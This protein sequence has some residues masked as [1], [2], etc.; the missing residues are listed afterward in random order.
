MPFED[1]LDLEWMMSYD[2][3]K[4]IIEH[5][6]IANIHIPASY[7]KSVFGF[8]LADFF[9]KDPFYT[10]NKLPEE[11][12]KML[13]RL[14]VC[15]SNEYITH[16]RNDD[17]FLLMQKLH[18]VV[19]HQTETEWHIFMPDCIRT[20]LSKASEFDIGYHPGMREYANVLDDITACNKR[21]QEIVNMGMND[22]L[23]IPDMKNELTSLQQ[24]YEAGRKKHL[25]L[26]AKYPWAK[27]HEQMIQGSISSFL[28]FIAHLKEMIDLF[29]MVD[30]F[31]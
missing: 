21:V 23:S 7:K 2:V 29:L 27:H 30:F 4:N 1:G 19:T 3:K 20:I 24:R 11:E 15:K 12:Q 16:P 18:L 14:I 5:C 13:S 10:V 17:K 25:A 8:I 26:C 6:R 22:A 31:M 9:K 28:G